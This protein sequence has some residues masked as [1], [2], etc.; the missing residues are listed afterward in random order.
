LFVND[1][2]GET[3]VNE[4]VVAGLGG[5]GEGEADFAADAAEID[6]AAEEFGLVAADLFNSGGDGEAHD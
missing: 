5:R 1:F 6:D 4:D 3:G 2:E